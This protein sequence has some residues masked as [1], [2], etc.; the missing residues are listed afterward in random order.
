MPRSLLPALLAVAL[1]VAGCG[2]ADRTATRGAA[3]TGGTIATL[4]AE[5]TGTGAE[6]VPFPAERPSD[7]VA[8]ALQ[9]PE[10]AVVYDVSAPAG[11]YTLEVAQGAGRGALHQKQKDGEVWVGLDV[12]GG[13]V[14]YVCS[15]EPGGEPTCRE[16][17]AGDRGAR[18]AAAIASVVGAET[19]RTTFGRA[20]ALPQ[21]NVAVDT[22]AG[23]QVSCLA[24]T[25]RG[26]D[27]RLCATAEGIITE[28]T[29][30]T[31]SVE[32]R[33]VSTDV[34]DADLEPPARPE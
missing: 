9:R 27:L 29:A 34:D 3:A 2:D 28:I 33:S 12:A 30:G 20:A 32:A 26:E 14:S 16:G 8:L 11:A 1:T 13:S 22:Q 18:A 4:P 17:D 24:V 6:R 25:D 7:V 21:T 31:T 15:A 10:A 19:I 5:T 23:Q